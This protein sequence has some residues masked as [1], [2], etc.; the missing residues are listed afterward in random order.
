[1]DFQLWARS[2]KINMVFEHLFFF[3]KY[4]IFF[5]FLKVL[6]FNL[7]WKYTKIGQYEMSQIYEGMFEYTKIYLKI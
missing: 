1:M 3:L 2:E 6:L 7:L 5:S 4:F